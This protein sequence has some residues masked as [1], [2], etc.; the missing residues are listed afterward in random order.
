MEGCYLLWCDWIM[1]WMDIICLWI[2]GLRILYTTNNF[3]CGFTKMWGRGVRHQLESHTPL[4]RFWN[5]ESCVGIKTLVFLR[6]LYL[7]SHKI[8]FGIPGISNKRF[9][10]F[11]I[12]YM[13]LVGIGPLVGGCPDKSRFDSWPPAILIFDPWFSSWP[14]T[15]IGVQNILECHPLQV[16]TSHGSKV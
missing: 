4:L 7:N 2:Y 1:Y 5:L 14:R 11:G 9:L 16:H 3:D 15:K 13:I 8:L 10:R 12:S 6:I